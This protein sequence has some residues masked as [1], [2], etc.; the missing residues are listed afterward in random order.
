MTVRKLVMALPL[1]LLVAGR[2]IYAADVLDYVEAER[3]SSIDVA[4]TLWRLAEL[5]YLEQKS[6]KTL[7]NY[8][9]QREFTIEQGVADIPTAFVAKYGRGGP[10]IALLAEFDALPGLNQAAVPRRLAESEGAP[11]HAC[12]HHLFGAASVAAASALASW[13]DASGVAAT[14]KLVGTPAEEGGSGKVY[15]ARAGVFDDVDVVLHWHPSDRNSASPSSSTANK[16]GRFTFLGRAAHAASAPDRG[17]SA[18]DGVEAMNYMVNLMR[19]HVPQTARIHYVITDGGDA[20]NIVPEQAQVYYYV[21]HPKPLQVVS[22]FKRVVKAAEA[23]AMG[24]ETKVSVEVMHGNY[25]VMPNH[26]L[27][28]VVHDNM[29]ALGGIRY[30][31]AEQRFAE[32]IQASFQI[33]RLPLGSEQHVQPYVFRQG[34]GSTDVGDVS[35]LVPTVGFTTATWVP[36]TSAHSW[37]AVAAG[38]MSIGHKGM[39]LATKLLAQTAVDLIARPAL[40]A[41]ATEELKRSQGP[42]FKYAALLGDRLPPLDYRR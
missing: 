6:S 7:Q 30:D 28:R 12:G 36:G 32:K 27:A 2:S 24:T 37:Q 1:L 40:I 33:P 17:R 19:E 3:Q 39:H 13:L 11:G 15:L 14:I 42:D 18:L 21:R 25:P 31:G 41:A 38:G 10:T 22:L 9:A 29:L 23:A 35:W 4:D 8:L 26:T 5:G 20:P 16:S 34:M